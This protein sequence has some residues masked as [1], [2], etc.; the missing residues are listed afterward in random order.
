MSEDNFWDAFMKSGSVTDY[1]NYAKNKEQTDDRGEKSY[2]SDQGK[3][4]YSSGDKT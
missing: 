1:L 2:G 4:T 3:G